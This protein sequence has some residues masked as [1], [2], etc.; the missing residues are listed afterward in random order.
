MTDDED[1]MNWGINKQIQAC[2][3]PHVRSE[4]GR[5]MC[6]DCAATFAVVLKP[7]NAQPFV[8]DPQESAYSPVLMSGALI[9]GELK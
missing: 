6:P 8:I 2:R 9:R 4:D 5:V 7:R 1:R 3:H